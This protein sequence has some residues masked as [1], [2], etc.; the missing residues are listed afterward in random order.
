MVRM[1]LEVIRSLADLARP[2][3]GRRN[4][5]GHLLTKRVR[6]HSESL[7]RSLT[8]SRSRGTPMA[9]FSLAAVGCTGLGAVAAGWIDLNQHLGWRWIQ[10][11]H[12][13]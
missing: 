6:Q 8:R 10:W 12:L 4:H 2:P 5:C 11:F 3:V 9:I 13:M 7:H 1:L